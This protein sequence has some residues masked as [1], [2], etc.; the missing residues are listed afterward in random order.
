MLFVVALVSMILSRIQGQAWDISFNNLWGQN[1]P[2]RL[3]GVIANE[4][5]EKSFAG[6]LHTDIRGPF[7]P[8]P[9]QKFINNTQQLANKNYHDN[10]QKNIFNV[11]PTSNTDWRLDPN[12]NG[13]LGNY[14]EF[15]IPEPQKMSRISNFC[16]KQKAL[17]AANNDRNPRKMGRH[18][19]SLAARQGKSS[20]PS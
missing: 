16:N 8:N 11:Q 9:Q 7:G 12:F 1:R 19:T 20:L 13:P 14:T 3:P 18:E 17:R 2:A 5:E 6:Q 15:M 10:Y 4:P